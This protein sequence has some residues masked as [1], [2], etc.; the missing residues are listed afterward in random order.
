[1]S[2]AE[3]TKCASVDRQGRIQDFRFLTTESSTYGI[4]CRPVQQILLIFASV[5]SHLITIM[6]YRIGVYVNCKLFRC[7][8]LYVGL[9]CL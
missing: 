6:F 2:V 8:I 1:M 4:T 3:L 5:T 7:M 9:H